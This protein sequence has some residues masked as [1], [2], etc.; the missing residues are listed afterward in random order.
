M[1][2]VTRLLEDG[3]PRAALEEMARVVLADPA[4]AEAYNDLA[5]LEYS[6]GRLADAQWAVERS[7]ALDAS[8]PIAKVTKATIEAARARNPPAQSPRT[9]VDY[10]ALLP[11]IEGHV[12]Q[13]EAAKA[14]A[15][16][17]PR[18]AAIVSTLAV[19]Q[20]D[21]NGLESAARTILPVLN[22]H[23][24]DPNLLAV[25]NEIGRRAEQE[26]RERIRQL[27][28][29][30]PDVALIQE[31]DFRG[32]LLALLSGYD[33]VLFLVDDNL[34]VTGFGLERAQV[35][36]ANEPQLLGVSPGWARTRLTAT[37]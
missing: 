24:D 10:Q 22:L 30:D 23:P 32:Q 8:S 29:K 7:L 12:A 13:N 35:A 11:S 5:V 20:L 9:E 34:F 15:I 17:E 2:E 16:L 27:G 37:R 31:T 33:R 25:A 18:S 14:I 1:N 28:S 6:N 19:I 26:S 21:V 36:L 4:Y 3:K